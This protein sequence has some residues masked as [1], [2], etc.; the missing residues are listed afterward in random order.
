[1]PQ[2]AMHKHWAMLNCRFHPFDG[3]FELNLSWSGC[4]KYRH[5]TISRPF[6]KW[7]SF[8]GFHCQI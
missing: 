1:M 4:I 2:C 7:T 3:G 5:R 6:T 8:I